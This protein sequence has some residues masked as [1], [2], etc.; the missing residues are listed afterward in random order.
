MISSASMR[1]AKELA[2][3]LLTPLSSSGSILLVP[4]SG[5]TST[6]WSLVPGR[7]LGSALHSIARWLGLPQ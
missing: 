2:D 6:C 7:L 1:G 5:I 3:M 4:S